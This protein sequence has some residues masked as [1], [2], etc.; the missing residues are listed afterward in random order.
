MKTNFNRNIA[1]FEKSGSNLVEFIKYEKD[2][3]YINKDQYFD[4]INKDLWDFYIGGYQV[5]D[6]WL[7][8]RKNKKLDSKEIEVFIKIVNILSETLK[9]MDK[10]DKIK[11][12]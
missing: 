7:K 3:V 6:K 11:I 2:R 5:L 4:N 12:D 1:K 8:S 9:L 10:I